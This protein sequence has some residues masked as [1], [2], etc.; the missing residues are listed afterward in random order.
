MQTE[1]QVPG[2]KNTD[3]INK[4]SLYRTQWLMAHNRLYDLAHNSSLSIADVWAEYLKE[5]DSAESVARK[6]A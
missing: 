3:N 2:T 4:E 5:L 6:P 1:L